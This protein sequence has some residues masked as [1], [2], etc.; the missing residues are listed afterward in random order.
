MKSRTYPLG[1]V[2]LVLPFLAALISASAFGQSGRYAVVIGNGSYTELGKLKNPMN[3]ADDVGEAL[4]GLGFQVDGIS[5]ADLPAMEDAVL[6]L[7]R[8]LSASKDSIGFFFYA[9]HGV[10]A[11]GVNY[12]IPADAHIASESFLRTKALSIQ[13][14]LDILQ[15]AHNTLNEVVLDACRDNPFSWA[16]S[17]TRGLSVVASQPPGSIIA[18]AT[19]AG[20][21][22]RDGTLTRR[23]TRVTREDPAPAVIGSC[24]ASPG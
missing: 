17:G 23:N 20:S 16:R 7:G 5:N 8:L 15:E 10:Q 9:G 18:Y 21:V 22:A 13:E 1:R 4:K 19:S 14:V 11:N 6:R 3:D 2:F 24:A 12:L